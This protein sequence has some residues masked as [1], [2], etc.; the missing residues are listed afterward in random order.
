[1]LQNGLVNLY[2]FE[3]GHLADYL[4]SD[5]HFFITFNYCGKKF[6]DALRNLNIRLR[7]SGFLHFPSAYNIMLLVACLSRIVRGG[8]LGPRLGVFVFHYGGIWG[9]VLHFGHL[10]RVL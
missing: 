4:S 7:H 3:P 10:F 6:S 8:Y 5:L 1:M 9:K 2:R